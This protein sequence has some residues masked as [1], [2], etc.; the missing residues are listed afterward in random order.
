VDYAIATSTI[1]Y[2]K[3]VYSQ[4]NGNGEGELIAINL[5]NGLQSWQ[6]TLQSDG[7]LV[8]LHNNTLL[9]QEAGDNIVTLRAD[10]GKTLWSYGFN[11]SNGYIIAPVADEGHA[12][13]GYATA[14]QPSKVFEYD[15]NTGTL[16]G[17]KTLNAGETIA[18]L[19][20]TA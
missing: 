3:L 15:E 20:I 5:K 13:F 1:L 19:P 10:N 18:S 2:L 12:F 7:A 6:Y 4:A 8:I 17:Q 16:L 14:Q 9:V 11:D